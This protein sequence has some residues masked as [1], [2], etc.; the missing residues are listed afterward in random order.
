MHHQIATLC[1]LFNELKYCKLSFL[2]ASERTGL[3]LLM[4]ILLLLLLLLLK[5]LLLVCVVVKDRF[6]VRGGTALR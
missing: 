6:Q 1:E 2:A 3:L 5:E 4:L